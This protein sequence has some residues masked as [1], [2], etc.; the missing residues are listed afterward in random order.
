MSK[1]LLTGHTPLFMMVNGSDG[2]A[3]IISLCTRGKYICQVEEYERWMLSQVA[4]NAAN[5]ICR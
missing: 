1:L 3:L 4:I 2:A 5:K